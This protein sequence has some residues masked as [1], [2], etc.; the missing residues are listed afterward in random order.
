MSRSEKGLIIG[1]FNS[2]TVHSDW[3]HNVLI[4]ISL[5][6]SSLPNRQGNIHSLSMGSCQAPKHMVEN[7]NHIEYSVSL[8]AVTKFFN[9]NPNP[10]E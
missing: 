7:I 4:S 3:N 5:K 1:W 9:P 6:P 2:E 10:A 8:H